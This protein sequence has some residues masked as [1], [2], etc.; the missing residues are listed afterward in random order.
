MTERTHDEPPARRR[1]DAARRRRTPT[2][3]GH[4]LPLGRG[5]PGRRLLLHPGLRA[6]R[7]RLRRGRRRARRVGARRRAR[8]AGRRRPAVPRRRHRASR[9]ALA[10]AE[11]YGHPSRM[12]GRSS[13]SPA[14]TARPRRPTCSTRSCALRAHVTGLIGTVE[15]RVAGERLAAGRTTPESSDLQALLARMRGRGRHGGGMEVSSHAIDL[16]RVDGVRF[17][18]AAFTNLTQDHLDYHHTIEEYF[19]VKRRLFTDF[20]VAARVVNIDDPVGRVARR[21]DAGRRSRSGR[22]PRRRRARRRRAARRS[23]ALAS[24]LVAGWRVARGARC[25]SPAPTT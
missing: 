2:V 20:D 16:H 24:T 18:V 4:R 12:H 7:S 9:L 3:S 10:A 14:P 11:F 6:R 21:R 8:A 23:R 5:A 17:A 1:G 19:S 15:T 25:R 13:A 22:T